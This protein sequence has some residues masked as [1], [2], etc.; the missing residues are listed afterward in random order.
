M[1]WE[2]QAGR[3][4]GHLPLGAA[5]GVAWVVSRGTEWP[6][7]KQGRVGLLVRV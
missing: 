3:A 2:Q 1:L 4:W 6:R 5:R 7:W